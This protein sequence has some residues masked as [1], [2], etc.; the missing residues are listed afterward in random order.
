MAGKEPITWAENYRQPMRRAANGAIEKMPHTAPAPKGH[1]LHG[2]RVRRWVKM[3][4][5]DGHVIFAALTPS[6]SNYDV[7]S[8]YSQ[9]LREKWRRKGWI[10]YAECPI[11]TRAVDPEKLLVPDNRVHGQPCTPGTYGNGEAGNPACCPHVQA[12]IDERR[13][14][15]EKRNKSINAKYES[16]ANKTL[17]LQ[18]KQSEE[19]TTQV[20][21]L[22]ELMQ[23]LVAL[24]VSSADPE[25]LKQA[26]SVIDKQT[27]PSEDRLM[28]IED[29]A[30]LEDPEE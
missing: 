6:S 7:H 28:S 30:A 1:E 15:N 9:M 22:A 24:N 3:V 13:K 8:P 25:K 18:V 21:K 29:L 20:S 26:Q 19:T 2:R 17:E 27:K 4:T 12:E 10:E 11:A 5:S 14:R 23:Q 16:E